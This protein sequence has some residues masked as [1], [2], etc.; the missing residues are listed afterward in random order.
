MAARGT[1]S[2]RRRL[3]ALPAALAL[4]FLLSACRA[5]YTRQ[6]QQ[7][8]A[9]RYYSGDLAAAAEQALAM[10][11]AEAHESDRNALLWHL[12]AGSINLDAGRY[13]EALTALERAEKL[14]YLFGRQ[15]KINCHRPGQFTYMG[16]RTDRMTLHLLK[17]FLY[18]EQGKFE[19]ALV[20]IRRMRVSQFQ[21][22][23]RE[24]DP[25][26]RVYDRDH[27]GQQV[28]PFR[29]KT[30]LEESLTAETFRQSGVSESFEKSRSNRRPR[31][32]AFFNPL[33]F[34]LSS[35]AYCWDNDFD[36]AALDLYYLSLLE[37]ENP[38]FQ[39]DRATVLSLLGEPVPDA[40]AKVTPWRHSL[41]DNTIL[42]VFAQSFAPGWRN[43]SV[44]IRLPD[45]VPGEWRFSSPEL[46]KIP[47]LT[48]AVTGGDE[49][50]TGAVLCDLAV[51]MDDEFWQLTMPSLLRDTVSQIEAMTVANRSAKAA[52]AALLAKPDYEG[53]VLAVAAASALV[54]ST[55]KARVIQTDWRRWWT[56][57]GRWQATHLGIPEDRR[58]E[59]TVA[60][61]KGNVQFRRTVAV[62][63]EVT[64][65]VLYLREI[66]GKY[67]LK[68]WS[69]RE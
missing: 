3:F 63:E 12:E 17:F 67:E 54:E 59:V 39:R 1:T 25:E 56:I 38:L 55:S 10:S 29:M 47:P 43:Q 51:V 34:Y 35:V 33:A 18:F 66:N 14:L 2:A 64:R 61:E 7:A 48:F 15:G 46:P 26:I 24:S 40:L 60:D 30:I 19:D 28:A 42:A 9:E 53:K 27:Y 31:L 11:D 41:V 68:F 4:L 23:L 5:D 44:T 8:L 65:G 37:P 69:S 52:L 58:L 6:D 20:E 49:T 16:Y 21:Y 57:G 13:A 45:R 62:P 32:A 22:L 36:E 50:A